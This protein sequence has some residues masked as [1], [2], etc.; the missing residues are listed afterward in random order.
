M[1]ILKK[2]SSRNLKEE[3]EN[4]KS[5]FPKWVVA[6]EDNSSLLAEIRRIYH[7][8]KGSGRLV[9]ALALGD[10]SWKIEDMTNSVLNG[11]KD[12]SDSFIMVMR[13]SNELL[14][15][16]RSIESWRTGSWRISWKSLLQL[17][18]FKE[19]KV[20]DADFEKAAEIE[21]DESMSQSVTDR[22]EIDDVYLD[23]VDESDVDDVEQTSE[24]GESD[25]SDNES[26]ETEDDLSIDPVFL[27]ILQ[28]EVK[29]HLEEVN[30]FTA[31]AH[32][33][34]DTHATESFIRVIH[35]LNG[36]ANMASVKSIVAMTSPLEI[37]SKMSSEIGQVFDER[38]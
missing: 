25:Q 15:T 34:G 8:L 5:L 14:P 24:L 38:H 7:T 23:K 18:K 10:Y 6:P 22:V 1:K 33:S 2:F 36:A 28:Q 4:V 26:E 21:L 9:G 37:A 17:R 31:N 35:T 29:G 13:K 20:T 19:E 32:E 30:N 11:S 12:L 16:L 27:E 3:L